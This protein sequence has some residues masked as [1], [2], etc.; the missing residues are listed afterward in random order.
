MT[1]RGRCSFRLSLL[2][3]LLVFG[4][5][6]IAAHTADGFHFPA[7]TTMTGMAYHLCSSADMQFYLFF[8]IGDVA[9]YLADCKHPPF[10]EQGRLLYFHYNHDFSADDLRESSRVLLK[11]N[12]TASQFEALKRSLARFNRLYQP[13]QEGD[14]YVLGTT[15]EGQLALYLNGRYLGETDSVALSDAYFRIWFGPE[16]FGDQVKTDLLPEG[17]SDEE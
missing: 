8:D 13:V 7:T 11:R 2:L 17:N 4:R 1:G 6:G 3:P 5:P 16:P 10:L 12:T 9:L 15:P 14:S